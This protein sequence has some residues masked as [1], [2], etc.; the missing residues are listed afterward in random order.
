[1]ERGLLSIVGLKPFRCVDCYHRFFRWPAKDPSQGGLFAAL[2]PKPARGISR[3][4]IN[5]TEHRLVLILVPSQIRH[6]FVFSI[7]LL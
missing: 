4:S 2:W 5:N 7:K 1:M 6:H 3:S